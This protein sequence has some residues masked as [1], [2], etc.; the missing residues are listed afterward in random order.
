[1]SD[2]PTPT[3]TPRVFH[4]GANEVVEDASTAHLSNEAMRNVL[5]LTYPE[6]AHATIRER[7]QDGVRHIE[8]LAVAGRKG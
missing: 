2:L 4:I 6:V 5:K 7:E 1:M 8:F 3:S